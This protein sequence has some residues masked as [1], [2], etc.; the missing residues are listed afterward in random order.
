M[1]GLS[2]GCRSDKSCLIDG[3]EISDQSASGQTEASAGGPLADRRLASHVSPP[4]AGAEAL[5][6]G[7]ACALLAAGR[8]DALA[9]DN[10]LP[11]CCIATR[12]DGR[13]FGIAGDHQSSEPYAITPCRDD[14]ASPDLVRSGFDLMANAG[15]LRRLYTRRLVDRLCV[16]KT[17]NLPMSLQRAAMHWAPGQPD[18]RRLSGTV[19]ELRGIEPLTSSLRTRR[20]PN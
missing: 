8:A 4:I 11:H 2:R 19:V 3:C 18:Q 15:T 10:L 16:G 20:S 5:G 9:S 14:A 12:P 7:V 17:L 13:R 6:L 1:P